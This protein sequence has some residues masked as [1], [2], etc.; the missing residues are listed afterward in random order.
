MKPPPEVTSRNI[1]LLVA[2]ESKLFTFK[3]KTFNLFIFPVAKFSNREILFK[4]NFA[5]SS[6]SEGYFFF[7]AF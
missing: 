5:I 2:F 3:N 7:A 1:V 6:S 4:P